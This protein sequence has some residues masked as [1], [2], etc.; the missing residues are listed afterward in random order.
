[1]SGVPEAMV[2]S[3]ARTDMDLQETVARAHRRI[4]A[5]AVIVGPMHRPA[6]TMEPVRSEHGPAAATSRILIVGPMAA[7]KSSLALQLG[8][9]LG[10]P[11][12]HLDAVASGGAE[13][14]DLGAATAIQT[15]PTASFDPRP[16]EDRRCLTTEIADWDGWVAE[17]AFVGWT[18]PLMDR[19]DVIVWLDHVGV[20]RAFARVLARASRSWTGET[21][22]R[23]REAPGGFRPRSIWRPR[24]YW[25]HGVELL[26]QLRD[27]VGYYVW[28]RGDRAIERDLAERRW[29]RV[30]RRMIRRALDRHRGRVIHVRRAED[31]AEVERRL[32]AGSPTAAEPAPVGWS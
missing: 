25:R 27:V 13:P 15:Q 11:V 32:R 4:T 21:S 17:G 22:R 3:P 23:S 14:V 20:H 29:D 10:L 12:V 24:S 1:V 2:P 18:E 9:R 6:L 31:L 5:H 16:L 28:T 8:R 26:G 7:G 19:A 30:D